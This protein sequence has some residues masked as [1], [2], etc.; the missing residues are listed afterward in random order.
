MPAVLALHG[1]QLV[2]GLLELHPEPLDL[3]DG[4]AL[5]VLQVRLDQGVLLSG[6]LNLLL[7]LLEHGLRGPQLEL[8]R[9][10]HVFE[11]DHLSG[12]LLIL[13]LQLAP[14]LLDQL[15]FLLKADSL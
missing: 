6:L 15:E 5:V 3:L 10:I 7:I 11:F 14:L 9:L 2:L 12:Q 13:V 1:H 8:D 4:G